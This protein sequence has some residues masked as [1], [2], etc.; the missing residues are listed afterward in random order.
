MPPPQDPLA[1]MG[2]LKQNMAM[3][4]PNMVLMGWVSYFFSGFVLLKLPFSL[5]D[6]FKQMLQRGVNL[7][8]LDVSYVSSISWY[9]INIFGF[10]GLFTIALGSKGTHAVDNTKLLSQQM[11]GPMAGPQDI[12][13]IYGTER[14][15]LEIHRHEWIIPDAEQRLLARM[16]RGN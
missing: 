10:R 2:M 14:T 13:K 8:S 5:T 3:I 7:R 1:M 16:R 4:I 12:T 6:S 9:F 15:E 11:S